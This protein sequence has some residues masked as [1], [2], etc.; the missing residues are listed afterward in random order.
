MLCTSARCG[1]YHASGAGFSII[2]NSGYSYGSSI[3]LSGVTDSNL[4]TQLQSVLLTINFSTA[5]YIGF[6]GKLRLGDSLTGP[7]VSCTPS[8]TSAT[9]SQSY[10]SFDPQD[11]HNNWTL[12]FT[13]SS[14]ETTVNNWSLDI[15]AVPEPANVALGIFA[16][17]FVVGSIS[18]N[19]RVR[20]RIQRW[21]DAAV[22][23]VDAV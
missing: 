22:R 11:P 8:G 14:S 16:G 17:L 4:G 13:S 12:V 23:W 15:T 5:D 7:Y 2:A 9:F 3:N 1:L 20:A 19:Q 18:Q 21:W 10:T 6:D